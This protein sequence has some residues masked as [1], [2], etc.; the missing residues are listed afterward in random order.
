MALTYSFKSTAQR[1]Y[2]EKW[3]NIFSVLAIASSLLIIALLLFFLYNVGSIADRLSERFLMVVY[4]TDDLPR[5][6]T[7][8]IIDTLKKREYVAHLKYIS[9]DKAMEE[10][11]QALGDL[12]AIFEGLD[13]NPLSPSIELRLK[14]DFVT[15]A[16]VKQISEDIKKIPGV[17]DIYYGKRTAEAIHLLK[18]SLQNMSLIIFLTI[19]SSVIF[20][21]YSTVK[22]LFYRRR[23][24]IEILKL[25]GATGGFIRAPFLIEGSI[26]GF[27]G[28][29]FGAVGSL[30]FYFAITY[31]L[32]SIIPLLKT[33]I[34]PQEI[35]IALP[36]IG[37]LL[38]IIGSAVATGRLRP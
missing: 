32:S 12:G 3:I 37:I 16:F 24:E 31:G 36:I 15:S 35:L 25:L 2:R 38:G 29:L 26:I 7:Q 27:F 17:D 5:E 8:D 6:K 23:E 33:L 28:G 9:K 18:K 20:I 11:K 21:T 19:S 4:L 13:E 1:L 34:F 30:V 14:K 10:L 22:N